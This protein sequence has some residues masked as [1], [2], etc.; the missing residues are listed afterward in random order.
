MPLPKGVSGNPEGRPAGTP[1]YITRE[2][3][4]ALKAILSDS[5]GEIPALLGSLQPKDKID[6]IIRLL[7]LIVPLPAPKKIGDPFN[8]DL[9]D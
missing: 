3:R 2:M 5:I 4:E 1:N 6:V 9:W 7:R 8:F